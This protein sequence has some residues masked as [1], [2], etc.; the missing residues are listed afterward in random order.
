MATIKTDKFTESDSSSLEDHTSNTGLTW[1]GA[2]TT[3]FEIQGNE[4]KLESGAGTGNKIAL[5]TETPANFNY[6]VSAKGRTITTDAGDRFGAVVRGVD[7]NNYYIARVG[8]GGELELVSVK[9][10]T[11]A[12]LNSYTI[13]SFDK[14][15][16]Y[17]IKLSII[18]TKITVYLDS[19]SVIDNSDEAVLSVGKVGIY[20]SMDSA[21]TTKAVITEMDSEELSVQTTSPEDSLD[22]SPSTVSGAGYIPGNR[23]VK[24]DVCDWTW[25]YSDMRLGVA[26]GQKGLVVCPRDFDPVHP[27]DNKPKPRKHE[28]PIKVS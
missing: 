16:Y 15:T 7:V 25:R 11:I 24:C 14:D 9:P 12:V 27:L 17:T 3:S 20:L 4:A 13:S 8:G 5:G 21:Y 10:G 22:P 1:S 6:F 2:D 19:T 28:E 26:D 23:L 18:G